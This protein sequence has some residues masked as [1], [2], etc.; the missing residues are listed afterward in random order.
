MSGTYTISQTVSV[1]Q[2]ASSVLIT[3]IG[4]GGGG[5]ENDIG[6]GGVGG[7]GAN[8]IALYSSAIEKIKPNNLLICIGAEIPFE[9]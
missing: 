7:G 9:L 1:P 8:V 4:G 5:G 2:F 6:V 3:A